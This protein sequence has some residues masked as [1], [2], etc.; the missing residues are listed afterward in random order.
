MSVIGVLLSNCMITL[1]RTEALLDERH[2]PRDGL[3]VL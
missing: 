1:K 2:S 3:E